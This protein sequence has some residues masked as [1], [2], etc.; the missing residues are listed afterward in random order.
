MA[1]VQATSLL[2]STGNAR[3]RRADTEASLVARAKKSRNAFDE[4]YERHAPTIYRYLCRRLGD[5]TTAEDV[6]HDVF[7]SVLRALPRYTER[8]GIPFEHWLLRI[9]T[10]TANR[11]LRRS[12]HVV[13]IQTIDSA[14]LPDRDAQRQQSPIEVMVALQSLSVR[15]QS[16]LVLHHV[17][18]LSVDQ[19]ASVLGCRAGTVKSRLHRAREALRGAIERKEH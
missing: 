12:P 4:L 16:V 9:A 3:G 5:P 17:E 2:D 8:R 7:V 1:T 15:Q 6:L 18:G 11:T 10:N 14:S 19:V 13:S